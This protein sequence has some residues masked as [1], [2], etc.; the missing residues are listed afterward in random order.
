M[1]TISQDGWQRMLEALGPDKAEQWRVQQGIEVET[2][3]A[4]PDPG[5]ET[6]MGAL[7]QPMTQDNMGV[8][9][10]LL[11][12]QRQS[13]KVGEEE[14]DYRRKLF[15]QGR[16]RLEQQR[17]GPS[18]A[19]Q[20]FALSAAFAAPQ[21]YKG[22]GGMMANVTPVLAEMAA[23]RGR[24]DTDRAAALQ[25]LQEQYMTGDFAARRGGLSEQAELLKTMASLEKPRAGRVITPQPGG[26]AFELDENGNVRTLIEPNTGDKPFGAPVAKGGSSGIVAKTVGGVT[27]YR[28]A[29]GKWYDNLE[30]AAAAGGP[31]QSASGGF[32]P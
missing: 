1:A 17:M 18:R 10:R 15:E 27:A 5:A 31:T 12:L 6:P 19:E 7:A 30:E 13:M 20:L 32:Q 26:G 8:G 11:A 2:P 14:R 3:Q 24:A 16:A 28:G 29:N 22:F 23:V 21:R 9:Q 25:K 4:L